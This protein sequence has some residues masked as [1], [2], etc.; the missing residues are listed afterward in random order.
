MLLAP[1]RAPFGRDRTGRFLA[2]KNPIAI[3]LLSAAALAV[4][5]MVAAAAHAQQGNRY[6]EFKTKFHQAMAI[7]D[8]EEMAKLVKIYHGE[9]VLHVDHLSSQIAER[10]NDALEKEMAALMRSW[11]ESMKTGFAEWMYQ[12]CSLLDPQ[13]KAERKRLVEAYNSALKRFEENRAGPKA[14]PTF[15]LLAGEFHAMAGPFHEIGDAFYSARCWSA[16]GIS[17]DESNRGKDAN[18]R[19]ACEGFGKAVAAWDSI[20][21]NAADYI[22]VKQ[23]WELL[24]ANGWGEPEADPNAPKAGDPVAVAN[25]LTAPMSF[26]ALASLAEVERPSYFADEI[27]QIWHPLYMRD[28]GSTSVFPA[29]EQSP[30][31]MRTAPSEVQVDVDADG[32]GDVDVPVTGNMNVVH[33][34]IGDAD[35][36]REWGFVSVVGIEQDNYQGL[37]ANLSPGE[38]VFPL[39][40]FSAASL[41]GTVGG[42]PVRLIDDNMDGL[43][44][45]PP[46]LWGHLGLSEGLMHPEV[47][48]IAI[49][50]SKRARPWS[51]FQKIGEQWYQLESLRGGIELKA[52][53][54]TLETGTVRLECKGEAPEWLVLR[55]KGK[56]ENSLFDV[57]DLKKATEVPT[58]TWILYYGIVRKG[59]KQQ[60]AKALIL[61]GETTPEWSVQAGKETVVKL[62]APYSFAFQQEASGTKLKV[63]GRSVTVV[64]VSGER[65]ERT[66]G[67]VPRPEV[68]WR[69]AGSRRASKPEKMPVVL[70]LDEL[71]EDG[72]RLHDYADCWRPLDLEIELKKD[73][74]PLEVQLVEK[75][76]KLFGSIESDWK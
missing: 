50:E 53:P 25:A 36:T 48:S 76:N 5:P 24:V 29:M 18:L 45:S 3:R 16:Y 21:M 34:A 49:G 58:G 6:D 15:E 62:G 2:M 60:I 55:G 4:P 69:K 1:S 31:V 38:D 37:R 41:T 54:V 68:A 14:G 59:K 27:Y 43:Y 32:K 46:K 33:F 57:A 28:I 71:K 72:T 10:S 61:P 26:K 17:F 11:K 30:K 39:Y 42:I 8:S 19:K 56:H 40:F 66:W 65:Y 35:Q 13:R 52:T 22:G 75:K 63:K 64:G 70:D 20:G 12:Y 23:R 9:A 74:G 7:A 47:D 73:E 67:C 51:E 44:G